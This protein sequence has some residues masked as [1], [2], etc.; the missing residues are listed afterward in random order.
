M[1]L[2]DKGP[3]IAPP[4]LSGWAQEVSM[5][6]QSWPTIISAMHWSFG[7]QEGVD[8]YVADDEVGHIHF[9]GEIHLV[10][11]KALQKSVI[12]SGLA[13]PFRWGAN[14]VQFPITNEPS[15]QHALWLFR[16]AYDHVNGAHESDLLKRVELATLS[17]KGA[18]TTLA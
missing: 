10:L 15:V 7:R 6:I 8:F 13:Q 18:T 16:L 11:T 12:G 14:W 9:D 1:K 2:A 3:V 17:A 5:E 4:V